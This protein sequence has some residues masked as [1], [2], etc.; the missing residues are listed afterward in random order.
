MPQAL[1]GAARSSQQLQPF[2]CVRRALGDRASASAERHAH[3]LKGFA[4]NTDSGRVQLAAEQLE[5]V[6]HQS[7]ANLPELQLRIG[8]TLW[9]QTPDEALE[10]Q[11][12]A[13]VDPLN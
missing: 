11:L 7:A 2:C 6:L 13:M 12:L 5:T 3:V 1:A 10:P 8:R 4:G 9:Q